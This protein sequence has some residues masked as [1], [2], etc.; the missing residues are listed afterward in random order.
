MVMGPA[1]SAEIIVPHQT[2]VPSDV[3]NQHGREAA[4]Y[5]GHVRA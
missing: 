3:R 4:Y 5:R 2:L 1:N